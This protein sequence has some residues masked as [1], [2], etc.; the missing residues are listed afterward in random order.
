MVVELKY[1]R[2]MGDLG[3][4]F[5]FCHVVNFMPSLRSACGRE[6]IIVDV[7]A[8]PGEERDLV[9]ASLDAIEKPLLQEQIWVSNLFIHESTT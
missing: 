7:R 8:A 9:G 4:E 6:N 2:E 5:S 3:N 1:P